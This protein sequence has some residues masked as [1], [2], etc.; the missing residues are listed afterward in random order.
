[1]TIPID[2]QIIEP[3]I[4]RKRGKLVVKM[5]DFLLEE[6]LTAYVLRPETGEE[7]EI[8]SIFLRQ[9]NIDLRFDGEVSY[10]DFGFERVKYTLIAKDDLK[11]LNGHM[12]RFILEDTPGM[13]YF[14]ATYKVT[15]GKLV[16]APE[17]LSTR[18]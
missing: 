7:M 4:F 8:T 13:K 9:W 1:M 12:L 5:E 11:K 18:R 3:I 2:Y 17:Y 15:N 6:E 16:P 14:E 10:D